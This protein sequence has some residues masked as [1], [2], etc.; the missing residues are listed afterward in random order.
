MPI[1]TYDISN[2]E[3]GLIAFSSVK[4]IYCIP[5]SGRVFAHLSC[6]VNSLHSSCPD[7]QLWHRK[8]CCSISC[9]IPCARKFYDLHMNLRS[10]LLSAREHSHSLCRLSSGLLLSYNDVPSNLNIFLLNTHCLAFFATI[11]IPH[12]KRHKPHQLGSSHRKT[13]T[14][15][16]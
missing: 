14:T 10:R 8:C 5:Y 2:G 16:T 7:S 3:T 15:L 1:L 9:V 13:L 4:E 6:L 11:K 12:L